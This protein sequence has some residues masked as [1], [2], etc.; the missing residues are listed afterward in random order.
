MSLQLDT[1]EPAPDEIAVSLPEAPY[2]FAPVS[3]EE[4]AQIM[5]AATDAEKRVLIWG[6]GTHQQIGNPVD[7]DV[8]VTTRRMD[9]IISHEPADLTVVAEAGVA[10]SVLNQQLAASG[11]TA[12]LVEN[13]PG[14]TLGGVIAAGLSGYH[15]ARYGPTRDRLLEV[16][17]VTGD[18][19]IVT[20]GG[21]VVKNVSGYDIPRLA[22][23]A[24]GSL[25]VITSVALKL[26]PVPEQTITIQL[27]DPVLAWRNLYRPV[28]V[29]ETADGA[30]AFLQGTEQGVAA[31]VAAVGGEAV[32]GF[33]WPDPPAGA[34]SWSIQVPPTLV[35]EVVARLDGEWRFVAQHGV[36][37]VEVAADAAEPE[38]LGE[39]RSWAEEAGGSLVW[40]HGARPAGFDPWGTPPGSLALQRRVKAAFDPLGVCNPGRLPGGL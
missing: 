15:R 7:P 35:G 24:L 28:A 8:V 25:G 3:R 6:G 19:R 30:W 36:G 16:T 14:A 4:T 20:G 26:W 29:L 39:L 33:V 18:G 17:I 1:L 40:R 12:A 23:G 27:E 13:A 31:Q 11:Q 32:A 37:V 9:T 5:A 2:R 34:Y 22:T 10:V 21:R 38:R